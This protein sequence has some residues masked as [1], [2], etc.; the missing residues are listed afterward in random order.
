[1]AAVRDLHKCY[2][3]QF[4][5]DVR[6]S[7][8]EL[9]ENNPYLR[10]LKASESGV[11]ILECHYPLISESNRAPYH[12]LHGFVDYLNARLGMQI[13]PTRF[14]GDIHLSAQEKSQPSAIQQLTGRPVPFWIIV[15]GGKYDFTIKWWHFR[16]FQA[17]VD[18]FREQ[19]L[20]VQVGDSAHYH[21]P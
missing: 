9:W 6:T 7:C 3:R 11:K 20:F 17:V 2:P 15:A 14:K 1:T 19:I 12:F 8:P 4:A 13:K 10:P 18:H 21:P 16:R 5:I